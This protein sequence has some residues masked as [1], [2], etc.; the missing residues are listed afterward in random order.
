MYRNK[1]AI[2]ASTALTMSVGFAQA[3]DMPVKAPV[4]KAPDTVPYD[5]W[6]GFYVG[7]N[8]GYSWGKADTTAGVA[9][10]TQGTP[11]FFEVPGG[12]SSISTKPVGVIG[13]GQ[14]GYNWQ[15]SPGW[16]AG[17]EADLQGS[18][19][20]ASGSGVFSGSTMDG[21]DCSDPICTYTNTTDITAKL[22][23]FGTARGRVGALWNNMLF[24]G[25]GGL[26]FG[27][28]SVS[29]TNTFSI[30]NNGTTVNYST[31]FSYSKTKTGW[32]AG[33]G[34]EGLLGVR[35]WTWR[36]EYL[37]ID[38]G[39]IGAGSFG[40]GSSGTTP[41]VTL[42]TGKFTDDIVRIGLNYH[43]AAAPFP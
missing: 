17:L 4:Y 42:S 15:F 5:P 7:G 18:G 1:L 41:S 35:N 16:L 40:T 14:V 8:V 26:A 34:I 37:H 10:F 13:G 12:A 30:T 11:I 43:F 20:K 9:P 28:V 3:A 21:P 31:P 38:L 24:Y 39:S 23:W 19:E 36:V 33:A 6:T 27:E 32:T 25:T 2:L 29:G 22:N